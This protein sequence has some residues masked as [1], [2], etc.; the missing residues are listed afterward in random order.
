MAL[1]L[2]TDPINEKFPLFARVAGELS[3]K[4][5]CC[6]GHTMNLNGFL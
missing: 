1:F 4:P 5:E 2:V 6:L 3:I